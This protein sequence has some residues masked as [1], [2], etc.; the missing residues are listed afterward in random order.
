[1]G[2]PKLVH[3]CTRRCRTEARFPL[4]VP[5]NASASG[6]Q[7]ELMLDVHRN[8]I[9]L[10]APGTVLN[11]RFDERSLD[12][13]EE[14]QAVRRKVR[15]LF[16]DAVA[17]WEGAAPVAFAETRK[18]WDFEIAVLRRRDCDDEGCTLASA[19][20]PEPVRQR[21]LIYPSM[22]DYDREEQLA[23]IAHEL[24]H[25]FGLRHYFADTDEDELKSPSLV[26]GKHSPFT[27]MNYGRASRLT[28]ADRNDLKRLYEA[29]WSQDPQAVLGRPVRL[30]EAPHRA[31][32]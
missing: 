18:D 11:W 19:F 20:F 17:A 22:F 25:I 29:A 13:H 32:A 3:R 9:P 24:G 5:S 16:R 15:R 31:R 30:V 7:P 6:I 12:R 21:M 23:T 1:M 8:K 10:W 14:P 4:P 2:R 27:I 28:D 26:F